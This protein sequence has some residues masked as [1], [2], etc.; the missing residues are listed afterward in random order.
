MAITASDVKLVASKVMLDVPEG[1][2]APSPTLITDGVSNSIFPDISELDRAGGRVNLRKVFA[3]IQTTDNDTYFGGNVIVADP[4]D[5]PRVSVTMFASEGFF[6]TRA[7]ATTRVEAYLNQGGEWGG[8]LW[9]NH[10]AGQRVIQLFQR[11]EEVLP[12]IGQTLVLIQNEGLNTE[13]LQYVRATAVTSVIRL[14]YDPDSQKDYEARIVTINISDALRQNFTGSPATRKFTR[15][16]PDGTK[17]RDTIVADAGTYVGAAPLTA[18]AAF[19]DFTVQASSIFTQLVP[20]AQTETPISDVRTNGLSTALVATGAAVTRTLSASFTT[21]LNLHVGGAILPGS[22]SLTRG[23]VTLTDSGGLLVNGSTQ[24]G[25]V[26]YDNGILTLTTNVFGTASGT[27][28]IAFTPAA[29]PDLITEQRAI[30]ITPENRSQSYALT[31]ENVPLPRTL[32][33]IYLAQGRWYVLR[34]TGAG[35]LSGNDSSVGGGTVSYSSGSVVITLGALPDSGSAIVIQSFSNAAT[36]AASNTLLRNSGRLFVPINSDGVITDSP[37]SKKIKPSDVTIEWTW[38]GT[39]YT[40]TDNGT[41]GLTGDATG[42]VDYNAGVIYFSPNLLPPPDTVIGIA[43]T[44]K[45]SESG[46]SVS[47]INGSI[48]ATNIAPRSVRFTLHGNVNYTSTIQYSILSFATK[49][50]SVEVRDT[51]AGTL[52]FNDPGSGVAVACGTINYA[53]GVINVDQNITLTKP[54]ASGPIVVAGAIYGTW[55]RAWDIYATSGQ[56]SGQVSRSFAVTSAEVAVE[57]SVDAGSG[58]T[59]NVTVSNMFARTIMVANYSLKGVS[60]KIGSILFDQITDNTLRYNVNPNTG[61][62]TPAGNVQALLGVVQLN[63]WPSG[64]SSEIIDWRGVISPPGDTPVAPFTAFDTFFRTASQPIRS[65]TLSILGTMQD[66]TTFNVTAGID[67]KINGTRIKGLVDYEYGLVQLYGVN[68]NGDPAL[69]VDLS[70]LGISGLTT[71]PRDLFK[72]NSIRYN[73]TAYSYLPLD[74]DII[75]IDPV[76]LPTDG[77]VPVFRPGGFAVVGHTGTTNALTVSNGQTVNC[78][79]VRLSRVRVLGN[80]GTVITTGYTADLEA[81]TVTFTNVSGY[82]QP[83]RVEHR[84]EDMALISDVQITGALT[85]TRPLTHAYPVGSYVSSALVTGDLKSRI[86]TIFDQQ[87]WGNAW[88]DI[89]AGNS[90]PA[91][92]NDTVY[93]IVVTNKGAITE[94]WAIVFTSNT[95][96]NVI[97][98]NVGVIATGNTSTDCSPTN[99]ATGVPYFTIP[100]LGWGLGWAAGNVLRFNSVAASFPVWVVRTILQG[101]ETVPNDDFTLLIRGDVDAA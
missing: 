18:A 6:D 99:P 69:N 23:G 91:T 68:P 65:G 47:T 43:L 94:R 80:N 84:I 7:Q 89:V 32:S 57:Y 61:I 51:G 79:R 1:G 2:G 38:G 67:G 72:L 53:T 39:T 49:S 98:E 93:P 28:T 42:S 100:A 22:F 82:S 55:T 74:A 87:T 8:F 31:M 20:S 34:D 81:G 71:I 92:F 76:R 83:V 77:R 13:K 12:N 63:Y 33:V 48:G 41:G 75:G 25:I 64:Q 73:A 27:H 70:H 10:I 36:V 37:G 54:D 4:P 24:V 30:R 86:S 46:N 66:G 56:Y 17:I 29:A 16:L 26:D 88:G 52:V 5:D 35:V 9:E 44:R 19:G 58:S 85:F 59:L 62:G 11:P 96:F 21:S 101:P 50:Y 40:A 90:A 45:N 60:F 78:G 3:S 97:G 15:Q 95:A 14:F